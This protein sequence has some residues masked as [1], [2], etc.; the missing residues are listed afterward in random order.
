MS[1]PPH[2]NWKAALLSDYRAN[3]IMRPC[4]WPSW[5]IGMRAVIWLAGNI[6]NNHYR[7]PIPISLTRFICAYCTVSISRY[8][9]CA[10]DPVIYTDC[11]DGTV[12][13]R[14]TEFDL[15]LAKLAFNN[16]V[17]AHFYTHTHTT[18]CQK[19]V[20]LELPFMNFSQWLANVWLTESHL[21]FFHNALA[22]NPHR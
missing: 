14:P 20:F 4:V 10:H 1:E 16:F 19:M 15:G 12:K 8:C 11:F 6:L 17:G 9:P 5:L 7:P 18:L 22:I 2:H 13:I 21:F 3:V